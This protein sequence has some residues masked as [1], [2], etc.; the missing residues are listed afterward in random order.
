MSS[1][2][3]GPVEERFV[4]LEKAFSQKHSRSTITKILSRISQLD[5]STQNLTEVKYS[6]EAFYDFQQ[7]LQTLKETV[8]TLRRDLNHIME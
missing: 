8:D 6:I 3:V 7:A 2:H 4:D 1:R 5:A